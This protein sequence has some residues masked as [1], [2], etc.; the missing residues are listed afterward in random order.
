MSSTRPESSEGQGHLHRSGER[1]S[2]TPVSDRRSQDAFVGALVG[3]L[4]RAPPLRQEHQHLVNL[5]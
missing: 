4:K 5:P 2:A 3:M 1:E